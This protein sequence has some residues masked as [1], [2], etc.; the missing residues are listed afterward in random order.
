LLFG[1]KRGKTGNPFCSFFFEQP[2]LYTDDEK[3]DGKGHATP[4][5][6]LHSFILLVFLSF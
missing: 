2:K 3:Y 6:D 5:S 1:R 4:K